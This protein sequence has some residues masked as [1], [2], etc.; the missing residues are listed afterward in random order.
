VK[1]TKKI[2]IIT[3]TTESS[4]HGVLGYFT[5]KPTLAQQEKLKE[6]YFEQEKADTKD[7]GGRCNGWYV[8]FTVEELTEKRI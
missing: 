4:D 7:G 2:W 8:Y 1:K 6:K 3:W 5:T